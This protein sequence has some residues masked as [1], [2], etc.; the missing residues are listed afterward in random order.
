MYGEIEYTLRTVNYRPKS[1]SYWKKLLRPAP[2]LYLRAVQ[3]PITIK[4]SKKLYYVNRRYVY[5]EIK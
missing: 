3:I 2:A 4:P 1:T 5:M